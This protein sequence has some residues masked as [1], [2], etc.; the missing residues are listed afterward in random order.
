MSTEPTTVRGWLETLPE[1]L[2]NYALTPDR[3]EYA[4]GCGSLVYAV[5]LQRD[6]YPDNL[7]EHDYW[8]GVWL[9]L[10]LGNSINIDGKERE[11]YNAAKAAY[12]AK[13]FVAGLPPIP[14]KPLYQVKEVWESVDPKELSELRDKA[15]K[16]DDLMETV[17]RLK[18]C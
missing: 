1:P 6:I 18:I 9:Y 2:K 14:T 8:H 10:R 3:F 11:G 13:K 5:E 7:P 4:G 16:W 17:K 12:E 15:A